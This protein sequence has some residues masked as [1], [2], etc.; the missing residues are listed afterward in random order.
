[1]L[2]KNIKK[3]LPMVSC[4]LICCS[5]A[6]QSPADVTILTEPATNSA[7]NNGKMTITIDLSSGA[8]PYVISMSGPGTYIYNTT[9]SSS[10]TTITGLAP[11]IYN[12][13]ITDQ[14]GCSA[15]FTAKVQKCKVISSPSSGLVSVMCEE[16]SVPAPGPGGDAKKFYSTGAVN[17]FANSTPSNFT[18]QVFHSLPNYLFDQ[19]SAS[20]D[21]T[22]KAEI[23]SLIQTDYSLYEVKEQN[24]F[25]SNAP[26]IF[27]FN[28]DGSIIWVYRN[29]DA[30]LPDASGRN[31]DQTS[32]KTGTLFPNPTSGLV[33]VPANK[34]AADRKISY[35]VV[36]GIGQI[37]LLNTLAVAEEAEYF[38]VDLGTLP[39]GLYF[40]KVSYH[41]DKNEVFAVSKL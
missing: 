8:T 18:F 16:I 34:P 20:V 14:N 40:I 5:L 33:N 25:Q 31:S 13:T 36:N 9:T 12:G 11:G 29:L 27:A 30:L 37:V 2:H 15:S 26:F 1:M 23:A 32:E 41:D 28:A 22:M 10:V 17:A 4:L 38:S 39:A 6:A 19:I 3:I 7:A 21:Y 24:E 35:K